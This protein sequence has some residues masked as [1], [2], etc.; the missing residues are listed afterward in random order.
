[1]GILNAMSR[2]VSGLNAQSFA[3]E[4]IAGNIANSQTTGFKRT[5]TTFQDLVTGSRGRSSAQTSGG[6]MAS[7]RSTQDV[8]GS[9]E[10]ADIGTYLGI[11]GEGYFMVEQ[12]TP[13]AGGATGFS[14]A[15]AYTR[16]GDFTLDRDGYLVNGAGYALKGFSVDPQSGAVMGSVPE[17]IQVRDSMAEPQETQT[18]DYRLNL[19]A[20]P[21]TVNYNANLSTPNSELWDRSGLGYDPSPA[22]T[23]AVLG[24]DATDFIRNSIAGGAVT[25]YDSNGTPANVQLRWAKVD[26]AEAGGADT[27]NLYYLE[28]SDAGATD[29]AWRAVGQDYVFGDNGELNP[30]ISRVTLGP[31]TIDGVALAGVTLD[32]GGTGNGVTQYDSPAGTAKVSALA[33]DGMAAGELTG[34]SVLDGGRVVASYSNGRDVDIAKVELVSFNAE[35]QLTRL[36]GGAFAESLDSGPPVIGASGQ[37]A[38][39]ALEASNVDIGQEFSKLI[40]T[41][42]AFSANSRIITTSNEMLQDVLNI[43]R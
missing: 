4:N 19:P 18:V 41:Q 25:V 40:V 5:D 13:Q 21:K 35:T 12:K 43:I 32:H 27:W 24:A 16:R 3:L 39:Q 36:D 42:Q 17:L 22:G 1:M 6:V 38:S 33:Q 8:Q 14:G 34:I 10:N 31:V 30:P 9:V 28:N 29:A 26:S 2:A 37:I 11:S 23:G 7:S 15:M 20:F